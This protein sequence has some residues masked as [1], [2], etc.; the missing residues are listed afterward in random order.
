MLEPAFSSCCC[1]GQVGGL[2]V[3]QQQYSPAQQQQQFNFQ[4][5]INQINTIQQQQQQQQ[6]YAQQIQQQ[7]QQQVMAAQAAVVTQ[8]LPPPPK[9]TVRWPAQ[10]DI[11]P[12]NKYRPRI[13]KNALALSIYNARAMHANFLSFQVSV[14]RSGTTPCTRKKAVWHHFDIALSWIYR[15]PVV[16]RKEPILFSWNQLLSLFLPLLYALW[17]QGKS[18]I[19]PSF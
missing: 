3:Q 11:T 14:V 19:L 2:Q 17:L 4:Q 16:K 9:E 8:P 12:L 7:Q 5:Q 10:N 15:V 18:P 6:H 1:I 13:D